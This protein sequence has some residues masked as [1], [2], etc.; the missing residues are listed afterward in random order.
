MYFRG[1]THNIKDGGGEEKVGNMDW[2]GY[3]SM[4]TMHLNPHAPQNGGFTTGQIIFGR[5]PKLQI[6]TVDNPD[7]KD[8]I[9]KND[10]LLYKQGALENS[11]TFKKASLQRDFRR[12]L[13]ISLNSSVRDMISAKLLRAKLLAFTK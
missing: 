11:G 2:L 4:R 10:T 13:N 12:N 1:I 3:E 5:S 7:I 6:G 9:Y 8:F